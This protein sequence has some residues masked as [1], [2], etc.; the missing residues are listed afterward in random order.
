MAG[1]EIAVMK[2]TPQF[3]RPPAKPPI[4]PILIFGKA[5]VGDAQNGG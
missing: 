2:I 3:W 1:V 5:T 4:S